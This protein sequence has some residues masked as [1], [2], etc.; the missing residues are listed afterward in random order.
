MSGVGERERERDEAERS[1][2][3]VHRFELDDSGERCWEKRGECGAGTPR[4]PSERVMERRKSGE[5]AVTS[6]D[7]ACGCEKLESRVSAAVGRSKT[8]ARKDGGE[9]G[10]QC[11]D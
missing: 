3:D 1:G 9:R 5:D 7:L 4:V 8:K 6:A 10:K 11:R 2:E